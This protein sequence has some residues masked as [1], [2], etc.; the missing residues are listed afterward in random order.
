MQ[1]KQPRERAGEAIRELKASGAMPDLR[2][3]WEVVDDAAG[4]AAYSELLEM[5]FA[6]RPGDRAA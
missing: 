3:R 5:L 1:D 4:R 6:P 2:V